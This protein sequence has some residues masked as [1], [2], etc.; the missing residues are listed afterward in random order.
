MNRDTAE[1]VI[2]AGVDR[3][4][5]DVVGAV[6]DALAEHGFGVLTEIDVRAIMKAKLDV[7]V[8]AQMILGACNPPLAHA[9]LEAEPSI[10]SLLPCN[11]VVRDDPGGTI[12]EAIDPGMLVTL[13]HNPALE[14]IAN[15]ASR[16]LGAA[17]DAL[18]ALETEASPR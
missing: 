2:D 13:T 10:G 3:P 16:R 15:E 4:F 7:D 11:V 9:A 17:L 1:Y 6:R 8:P 14:R 5:A 12:V 18:D